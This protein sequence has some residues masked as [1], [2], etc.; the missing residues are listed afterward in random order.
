[1]TQWLDGF[2]VV[3]DYDGCLYSLMAQ[4]MGGQTVCYHETAPNTPPDGAGPFAVFDDALMARDFAAPS[5]SAAAVYACRYKKSR[6]RTLW[7]DHWRP[8]HGARFSL[9]TCPAGTVLAD[10]VILEERLT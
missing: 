10:E 2:K 1:M 7:P 3:R 5:G 6:A 4:A 8:W 9:R